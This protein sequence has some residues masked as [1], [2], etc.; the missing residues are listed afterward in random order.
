MIYRILADAVVIIH[1][2]W[3]VFLFLGGFFGRKIMAVKIFHLSGLFFAFFIQVIKIPALIVIGFWAIIQFASG[4]ITQGILH[5][6]GTAWF[7]HVGGFLA[8]LLTIKLWLPR[9]NRTW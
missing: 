6:G 8:G 2:L 5:Q 4:L 9:R 7:A 1:F 3:I